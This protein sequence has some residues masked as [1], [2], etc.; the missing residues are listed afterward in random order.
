MSSID[1]STEVLSFEE[2]NSQKYLMCFLDLDGVLYNPI[3]NKDNVFAMVEKLYPEET[4]H[5]DSMYDI[6]A[7]H[8][9]DPTALENFDGIIK[10]IKKK[11]SVKIVISS[12]WRLSLNLEELK[13]RLAYLEF[14]KDI[15]DKTPDDF[16]KEIKHKDHHCRGAQIEYWLK[17]NH[18][19]VFDYFILDDI[20]SCLSKKFKNKFFKIDPQKLLTAETKIQILEQYNKPKNDYVSLDLFLIDEDDESIT[21]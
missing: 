14:S 7:T 21:I 16:S 3:K 10:E 1:V 19:K 8:F 5:N 17:C 11:H 18:E 13:K 9:F 12:N 4:S 2:M 6:A 15:F 20:D